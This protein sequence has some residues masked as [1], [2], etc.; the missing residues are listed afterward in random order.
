MLTDSIVMTAMAFMQQNTV[1][2]GDSRTFFLAGDI[3]CLPC[4]DGSFDWEVR[5][6]RNLGSILF[7]LARIAPT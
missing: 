5:K 4:R 1:K 7:A 3:H 2:N 6:G